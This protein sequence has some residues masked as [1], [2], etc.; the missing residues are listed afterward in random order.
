MSGLTLLE[1]LSRKCKKLTDSLALKP[2]G[3]TVGMT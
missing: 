1:G 3:P 2:K